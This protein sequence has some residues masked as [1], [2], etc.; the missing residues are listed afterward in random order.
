M[1]CS[2][3]KADAKPTTKQGGGGAAAQPAKQPAADAT[4]AAAQAAPLSPRASPR[5]KPGSD[6]YLADIHVAEHNELRE[7]HDG[8]PLVWDSAC[9]IHA[10]KQADHCLA[11]GKMEHGN[12]DDQGQNIYMMSFSGFSPKTE[13]AVR[14]AVKSWYSEIDLYKEAGGGWN[15]FN[16]GAG[17]F[18]QLVW[19]GTTKVGMG[20]ARSD[21]SL[22]IVA[23]YSPQGNIMM[24]GTDA[25]FH[26]N[27]I[28]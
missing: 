10:Q 1:G 19:K 5:G 3:S 28:V 8:A 14:E 21:N 2:S 27:V 12:H 11:L 15:G 18:T 22:Y 23:N 26:E 4:P 16:N 9:A 7:K 6:K 24:N 17:H 25:L 20:Y 13:D